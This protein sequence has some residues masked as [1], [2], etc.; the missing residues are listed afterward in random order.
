MKQSPQ[1]KPARAIKAQPRAICAPARS[2]PAPYLY[3]PGIARFGCPDA[4]MQ[5]PFPHRTLRQLHTRTQTQGRKAA[6]RTQP[7]S[8]IVIRL[9]S[10]ATSNAPES[11]SQQRVDAFDWV[12]RGEH[13][14]IAMRCA[15]QLPAMD[16]P[17]GS[18]LSFVYGCK[19]S[20]AYNAWP[21]NVF[22][23]SFA[24]RLSPLL[25]QHLVLA[26]HPPTLCFARRVEDF[27]QP[28]AGKPIN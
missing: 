22:Q 21:P 28:T 27:R 2:I 18:L 8:G 12:R 16:T 10:N 13:F 6:N 15:S 5:S 4:R 19:L 17:L 11:S 24:S 20:S 7:L 14:S 3:R 26:C 1:S 25:A 9:D 23:R